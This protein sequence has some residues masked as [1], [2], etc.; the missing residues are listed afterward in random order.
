MALP[1]RNLMSVLPTPGC[2]RPPSKG[3]WS[4][5][6]VALLSGSRPRERER[7][8]VS[9]RNG[10]RRGA[11]GSVRSSVPALS[12]RA[13]CCVTRRATPRSDHPDGLWLQGDLGDYAP[14]LSLP[15]GSYHEP[16]LSPLLRR[17]DARQAQTEGLLAPP[18]KRRREGACPMVGTGQLCPRSPYRSVVHMGGVGRVPLP[19]GNERT[20][21]SPNH[22]LATTDYCV[23]HVTRCLRLAEVPASSRCISIGI[24]IDDFGTGRAPWPS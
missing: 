6:R 2:P 14:S 13:A 23:R 16:D 17:R 8:G 4:Q 3:A 22:R 20:R 18:R 15:A 9:C 24:A 1:L 10:A 7:S 12:S 19:T 21:R 11:E 5:G